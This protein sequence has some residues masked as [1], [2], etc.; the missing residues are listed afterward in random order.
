VTEQEVVGGVLPQSGTLGGHGDVQGRRGVAGTVSAGWGRARVPA[1]RC[2][3]TGGRWWQWWLKNRGRGRGSGR[4][5][6]S[7]SSLDAK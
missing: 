2:S 5:S 4:A 1:E 7:P 6:G 3:T